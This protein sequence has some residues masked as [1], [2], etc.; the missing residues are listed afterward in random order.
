MSR[1]L[2][3]AATAAS[4]AIGS[5]AAT[6]QQQ[7]PQQRMPSSPPPASGATA[8]GASS[9]TAP[10]DRPAGT[11]RQRSGDQARSGESRPGRGQAG[12]HP[13]DSIASALNECQLKPQGERQPCIDKVI[14]EHGG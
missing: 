2:L 4:L 8:P 6:A 1:A 5:A 9:T 12:Q 3:V 11:E 7:S 13:L 10:M 14:Q